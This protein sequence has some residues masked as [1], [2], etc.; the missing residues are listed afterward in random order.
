MPAKSSEAIIENVL[1]SV[2]TTP[3]GV[4]ASE[5][6]LPKAIIDRGLA[7]MLIP[8]RSKF[9]PWRLKRRVAVGE[10]APCQ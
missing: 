7:F 3:A 2:P 6:S 10:S 1:I 9:P 5:Q 8:E 4:F